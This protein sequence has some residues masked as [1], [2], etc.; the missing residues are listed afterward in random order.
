[1]PRMR[2]GVGNLKQNWSSFAGNLPNGCLDDREWLDGIKN[3]HVHLSCCCWN[4]YYDDEH[5]LSSDYWS[6]GEVDPVS[7]LNRHENCSWV[8]PR[9]LTCSHCGLIRTDRSHSSDSLLSQQNQP[10]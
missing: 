10:I 4:V 7:P 1:M 8:S 3:L 2:N 6:S 9:D 5:L